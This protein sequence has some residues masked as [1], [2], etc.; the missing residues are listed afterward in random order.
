MYNTIKNNSQRIIIMNA[1]Y[2]F[3]WIIKK[4]L[5][6]ASAVDQKR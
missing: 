4:G 3:P 5:P 2:S 1:N 6:K